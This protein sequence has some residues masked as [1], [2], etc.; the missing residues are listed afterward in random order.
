MSNALFEFVL[1]EGGSTLM[2]HLKGAASYKS[3]GTSGLAEETIGQTDGHDL[4]CIVSLY[5][6]SEGE[7]ISCLL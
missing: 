6:P 3:F 4:L 2:K 5:A 1:V 7:T